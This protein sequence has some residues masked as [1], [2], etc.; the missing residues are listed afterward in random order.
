MASAM[1][2]RSRSSAQRQQPRMAVT[3]LLLLFTTAMLL[4]ASPVA[5]HSFPYVPTQLLMPDPTCVDRTVP[6]AA[7]D[8]AYIFRQTASGSVEFRALNFSSSVDADDIDLDRPAGRTALPFL[9]NKSKSTAYAAART[10]N[11]SVLL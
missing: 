10:S 8:L 9:D 6:C 2:S 3:T 11:G 7:P 4:F 1:S 5:A